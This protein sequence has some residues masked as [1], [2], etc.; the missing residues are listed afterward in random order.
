M[1]RKGNTNESMDAR[2]NAILRNK[3]EGILARF[4]T[5]RMINSQ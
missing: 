5:F 2:P 4:F 1:R 3:G